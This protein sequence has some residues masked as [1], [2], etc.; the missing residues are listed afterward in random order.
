MQQLVSFDRL[1][2]PSD[3]SK[4]TTSGTQDL[5]VYRPDG[6]ALG[7]C[8]ENVTVVGTAGGANTVTD[9]TAILQNIVS[10]PVDLARKLAGNRGN[11]TRNLIQDVSGVVP[12]GETLLVLGTPGAG[13]STTLHAIASDTECFIETHGQINYSTISSDEVKKQF[14][15]EIVYNGEDDIHF[16]QLTV[17]NTI[18]YALKLRQPSKDEQKPAAFATGMRGKLLNAFGIGHTLKTIVG[19][20]FV[21]GVSG[22]E[23][24][25]V[26]LAE[27]LV[28][29]P[30]VACWDNPSRGLDSSSALDFLRLLKAMSRQTGMTNIVTLYQAAESMY[31][32]CFDRV[33]VLYQ[34]RL[35]FSGKAEFAKQY[36]VEM[37]YLCEPR[38]TTPDFLTAVTSVTERTVREDHV[39]PVPQTPDEFAEAFRASEFYSQLQNDIAAY[40]SEHSSNSAYATEFRNE[41]Q[42][43]KSSSSSKT[44]SQPHSLWSQIV[45]GME[46]HYQVTWGD[47]KTLLTLLI[48]NAVNAVIT[49]SCFY[50]APKTATGS[51]ERGGAIF[52]AL[53]YFFLNALSETPST[54]FSRVVVVKQRKLGISHPAAY[55]ISQTLADIP[56]QIFQTLIFSCCYYFMLGLGKTA[57]QFWIFELIV[58]VHY[59][60]VS[61]LFRMLGAIAPDLN[62]ALLMAGSSI[63]VGLTYSGFA[64]PTPTF[65]KWGSWIKRITPS[66]YALEA[67]MGNE[68]YDITLSCTDTQLVPSGPSYT[69]L[70]YQGCTLPGSTKGSADVPGESYLEL[71]YGFSRSH[72]WQNFGI[73]LCFWFLYTVIATLALSFTARERGGS[74]GRVF[75][76]GAK[77]HTVESD[78][79]GPIS[80]EKDLEKQPSRA[81]HN[82]AEPDSMNSSFTEIDDTG[83]THLPSTRPVGSGAFFTFENVNYF[84]NVAGEEKQLLR[85]ISGYARP[86]QLTALMGASGAGKTTLLDNLSQRKSEGR[87]EGTMLING[88]PLD[89]SFGRSC[90]FCMQQDVHEPMTTVREA[91]QFSAHMR[92]PA[93]VPESEKMAYVEHI[94]KLLEL[95]PIADALIGVP[96]EGGLGVEERKRVTIG[97]ELAA[98]PSALLFLDEPTSGLDSQ[99]AYSIMFFLRKIAAEGLPIIC[100]IHQPSGVLFEMFDHILLLAPGGRTIYFGETGSNS[101]NVV[102]YF[103]R[104]GAH[105]NASENPA[106][107]MISTVSGGKGE[108][109]H[110]YWNNSPEH[111]KLEGKITSLNENTSGAAISVSEDS[112]RQYALPLWAQTI[113]L[114]KRHWTAVYRDGHYNFSK[115]FKSIWCTL[116]IAFTFY[117]I[118]SD[119]QG[120]QNY[121]LSLLILIQVIQA[122]APDLQSTWFSK[123]GTF[124]ARE[125]NG[126]Y[127]YKALTTALIV[128]EIPWQIINFTLVFFCSYWTVGF[129]NSSTIAGYSYFIWLLLSYFCTS[130]NQ[131]VAAIFPNMQTAGLANSL[132]W[133]I[134]MI[135]SGI[136]VPHAS[137]NTF[138]RYWLYWLDPFRWFLG[139]H[140]ENTLHNVQ[141]HCA[142]SDLAIFD[143]PSGQTCGQ[144]AADFLSTAVGYLTN[145]DATSDCGY[146]AYTTGDQYAATMDFKY[147]NRWR[148]LG[149][150]IVF[151]ASNTALIYFAT[152]FMRVRGRQARRS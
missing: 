91:L 84:V 73:I 116:F 45:I 79:Q 140:I 28:T 95:G 121:V 112:T 42:R 31:Q 94:I 29:N 33:L 128:V 149:L 113:A 82:L 133:N 18:D 130:W 5:P 114:T 53:I 87:I 57:S 100:T 63:P 126:I 72:L 51:Y 123:W 17:G 86:G 75:K 20:A 144:Y 67:L 132:F 41:A 76:R 138:Y 120:L 69:D 104:Y 61:A 30:A 118:G 34:G 43:I 125:R 134:L 37:G 109:W 98:K 23:R 26:S 106:E 142:Q 4:Q 101:K 77:A 62:L 122:L 16:P 32:E 119:Q 129:P 50:M 47:R 88:Q 22:G 71:I 96:G 92:Q 48:L 131:L 38:Q 35:I 97:V 145:E 105:M 21:R 2:Y 39:G 59:A 55:V 139:G 150:C 143:P 117:N 7:V 12:A 127:D 65:H 108:E 146:C 15:S 136:L 52:F 19:N 6:R 81:I 14:Q 25:R 44:S 111:A 9:F 141:V 40:R 99:A 110:D 60:A 103:G 135:F 93:D 3:S 13:C 24:K 89:T 54:V 85:N 152:W 74:G 1:T 80:Q 102:E 10:A 11:A 58:F 147:S 66:P 68:F 70:R 115:V 124:E 36:F 49:G 27:V 137:L 64:P 8:F 148:D 78:S 107:F 56:I 46:R 90:G 151:C 83:L